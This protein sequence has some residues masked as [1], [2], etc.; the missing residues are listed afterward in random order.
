MEIWLSQNDLKNANMKSLVL[1]ANDFNMCF[2]RGQ[3]VLRLP[4]GAKSACTTT[5]GLDKQMTVDDLRGIVAASIG[6]Q[7]RKI[8]MTHLGAELVGVHVAAI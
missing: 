4:M 6:I 5:M 2:A 3:V 7:K 1:H 8:R